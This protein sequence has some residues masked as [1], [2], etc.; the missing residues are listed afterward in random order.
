MT[1]IAERPQRNTST[2]TE[3]PAHPHYVL[4]T[5]MI[6]ALLIGFAKEKGGERHVEG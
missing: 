6:A 4:G 5:T 3:V 2:T 1:T